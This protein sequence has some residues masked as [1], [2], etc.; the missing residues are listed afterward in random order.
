MLKVQTIKPKTK[1]KHKVKLN[2]DI[3]KQHPEKQK[4][5]NDMLPPVQSRFI[6]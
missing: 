3:E 1:K 6:N 5:I 4:E 2:R